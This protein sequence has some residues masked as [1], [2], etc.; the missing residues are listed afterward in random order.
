MRFIAFITVILAFSSCSSLKPAAKK[1]P[2][3]APP[4]HSNSS[5]PQFIENITI[6]GGSSAQTRKT[7]GGPKAPEYYTAPDYAVG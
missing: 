6:N 2:E 7:P 4:K 5:Q 1:Q 3:T